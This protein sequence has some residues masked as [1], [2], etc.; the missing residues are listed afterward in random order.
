MDT[1]QE[2]TEKREVSGTWWYEVIL[3]H[4]GRRISGWLLGGTVSE[5]ANPAQFNFE[6]PGG[7]GSQSPFQALRAAVREQDLTPNIA[8]LIN[9]MNVVILPTPGLS[10]PNF[11]A[12]AFFHA[13]VEAKGNFRRAALLVTAGVRAFKPSDSGLFPWI[14]GRE[15]PTRTFETSAF[16][17]KVWHFFWNAHERFDG[18]WEWSLDLQGFLYEMATRSRPLERIRSLEPLGQDARED[19]A[20]NRAGSGLATW[21]GQNRTA[22]A[23]HQA[24][25]VAQAVREGIAKDPD[26]SGY[27]SSQ[28]DAAVAKV[29]T[30]PKVQQVIRRN[31]YGVFADYAGRHIALALRAIEPPTKSEGGGRPLDFLR[32]FPIHPD[33]EIGSSTVEDPWNPFE[34]DDSELSPNLELGSASD[35]DAML[36]A[37][38]EFQR[39]KWTLP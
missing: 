32:E 37:L 11:A 26:R 24:Q 2:V 23:K 5:L 8:R 14:Q 29:L 3:D 12:H 9:M 36:K 39:R 1:V 16:R 19:V 10:L 33:F 31:S 35:P 28:I 34:A 20:F 22:V 27:S 30:T 25:L 17:D 7:A 18:S 6:T 4:G 13:L 15:N 38:E 21:I